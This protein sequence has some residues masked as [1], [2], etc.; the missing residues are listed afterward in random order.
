VNNDAPVILLGNKSDLKDEMQ[1]GEKELAELAAKYSMKYHLTSAKTGA[2]VEE[3]FI[4]L[5]YEVI[6]KHLAKGAAKNG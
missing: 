6:D 1:F 2:H 5:G 3:S 4:E